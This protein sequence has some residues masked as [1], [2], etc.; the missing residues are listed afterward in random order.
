[1]VTTQEKALKAYTAI[2]KVRNKVKGKAALAL[3]KLKRELQVNIDYQ[4]E[5][6]KKLVEEYGGIIND[7][8]FIEIQDADKRAEFAKAYAELNA[9][10]CSIDSEPVTVN[11][12]NC[13]DITLEEIESLAG[14]VNFE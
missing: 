12:D 13:P 6:E 9:T 8:G 14:F 3:Y 5:E 10:E 11:M 1:M 2:G 4:V 7:R